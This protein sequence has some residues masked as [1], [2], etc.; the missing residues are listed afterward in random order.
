MRTPVRIRK[1]A[2][3]PP[4]NSECVY[5]EGRNDAPKAPAAS[6]SPVAASHLL[7]RHSTDGVRAASISTPTAAPAS[8]K[9]DHGK[10]QKLENPLSGLIYASSQSGIASKTV[11]ERTTGVTNEMATAAAINAVNR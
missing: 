7:R 1:N 11:V 6:R 9:P 8:T 10:K 2:G 5:G 4:Q 3:D